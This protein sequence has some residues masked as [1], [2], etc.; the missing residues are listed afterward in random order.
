MG[1]RRMAPEEG[2]EGIVTVEAPGWQVHNHGAVHEVG[3]VLKGVHGR[4]G[5]T[6]GVVVDPP[7]RHAVHLGCRGDG[8]AR[9]LR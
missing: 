6:R 9:I 8:F 1:T 5:A 2:V 3:E 4:E 7:R